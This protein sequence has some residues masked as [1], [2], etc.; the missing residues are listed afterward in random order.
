MLKS[1]FVANIDYI[2]KNLQRVNFMPS[3]VNFKQRLN[4]HQ[5]CLY[6]L[7]ALML[8]L[9]QVVK[10]IAKVLRVYWLFLGE[11]VSTNKGHLTLMKADIVPE[12]LVH[13]L[14]YW[15]D[16]ADDKELL[17]IGLIAAAVKK[18]EDVFLY[19]L[20]LAILGWLCW[21]TPQEDEYGI[22]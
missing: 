9:A 11:V 2:E 22:E 10:E 3:N 14:D 4:W 19:H 20:I 8:G 13:H 18:Y 21:L 5:C 15:V 17:S 6:V 1:N 7:F 12:H 16:L